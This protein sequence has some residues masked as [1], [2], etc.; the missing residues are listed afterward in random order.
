MQ[1]EIIFPTPEFFYLVILVRNESLFLHIFE[2]PLLTKGSF[3]CI[4]TFN[5]DKL[6]T[7]KFHRFLSKYFCKISF[8]KLGQF[9]DLEDISKISTKICY[10]IEFLQ[11]LHFHGQAPVMGSIIFG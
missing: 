4:E 11:L 5:L 9:L 2:N 7:V 3:F 10:F 6:K 1:I 8:K